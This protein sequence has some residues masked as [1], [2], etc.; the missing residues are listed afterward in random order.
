MMTKIS[1][2]LPTNR[3]I[4]SIDIANER[5]VRPGTPTFGQPVARTASSKNEFQKITV[6]DDELSIGNYGPNAKMSDPVIQ[7]KM[8]KDLDSVDRMNAALDKALEAKTIDV[9][10]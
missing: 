10:V 7:E 4:S 6:T 5:A 8:Q 2:I 9:R 3:R 1:G